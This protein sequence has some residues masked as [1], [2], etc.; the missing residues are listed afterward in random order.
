MSSSHLLS[1]VY[2]WSAYVSAVTMR[3]S[4]LSLFCAAQIC[5]K[6][7]IDLPEEQEQELPVELLNVRQ[8]EQEN[9]VNQPAVGPVNLH[10]GNEIRDQLIQQFA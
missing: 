7:N 10:R 9:E 5:V 1:N 2:R 8:D 4:Y 3:E 6:R